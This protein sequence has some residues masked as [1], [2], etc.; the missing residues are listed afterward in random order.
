MSKIVNLSEFEAHSGENS[1]YDCIAGTKIVSIN[2]LTE[3]K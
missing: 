1:H 2:Q 3:T